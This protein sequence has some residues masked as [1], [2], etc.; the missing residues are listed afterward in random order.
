MQAQTFPAPDS[1]ATT[2]L[3]LLTK[4]KPWKQATY[5]KGETVITSWFQTSIPSS[6]HPVGKNEIDR[7]GEDELEKFFG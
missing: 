6:K 1:Q 3:E 4:K 2:D 5:K 7:T